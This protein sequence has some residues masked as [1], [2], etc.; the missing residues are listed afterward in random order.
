MKP[1]H[2]NMLAAIA[3]LGTA[4]PAFADVI[5]DWNEKAVEFGVKRSLLPPP[6]ER[7][8]ASVSSSTALIGR[9]HEQIC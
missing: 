6:A 8:I 4:P 2:L 9:I 3:V 5:T 7:I 1:R